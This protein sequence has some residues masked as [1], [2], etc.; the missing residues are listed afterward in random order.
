EAPDDRQKK[1]R[2]KPDTPSDW[3]E[4]SHG[5]YEFTGAPAAPESD[6]YL[7]DDD[8]E[9]EERAKSKKRGEKLTRT[10]QR[11]LIAEYLLAGGRITYCKPGKRTLP[12][13]AYIRAYDKPHST[14]KMVGV[15]D[16]RDYVGERP[17]DQRKLLP[18]DGDEARFMDSPDR[19][20]HL[21]RVRL[22][23]LRN[24]SHLDAPQPLRR[25]VC[26]GAPIWSPAEAQQIREAMHLANIGQKGRAFAA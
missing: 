17:R 5:E 1:S 20:T 11:Q 18:K 15:R 25:Y 12:M 24:W 8:D 13:P 4:N 14:W 16:T 6:F 22:E 3:Q 21:L 2:A 9:Y 7:E 10:E 26:E 23:L 19:Q